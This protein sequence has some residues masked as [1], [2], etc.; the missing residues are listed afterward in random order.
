MKY[1]YRFDNVNFNKQEFLQ[2]VDNDSK[3]SKLKAIIEE[4]MN[5]S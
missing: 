5:D 2:Y 1:T 4:S 3:L